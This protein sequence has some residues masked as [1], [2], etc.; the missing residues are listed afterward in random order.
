MVL[1]GLIQALAVTPAEFR[2]SITGDFKLI[3]FQDNVINGK[4]LTKLIT[5]Q[6]GFLHTMGVILVVDGEWCNGVFTSTSFNCG[7]AEGGDQGKNRKFIIVEM[8][9]DTKLG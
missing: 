7:V 2:R 5:Q 4:R 1:N 6:N 3:P 8:K 9:V